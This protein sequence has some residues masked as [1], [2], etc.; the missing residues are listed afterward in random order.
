MI[1]A[2]CSSKN[3]TY[4]QIKR[5]KVYHIL[6]WE[7]FYMISIVTLCFVF[8]VTK[9]FDAKKPVYKIIYFI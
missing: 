9:F 8:D 5:Q 3:N 1:D 4:K 2:I 7:N 6:I